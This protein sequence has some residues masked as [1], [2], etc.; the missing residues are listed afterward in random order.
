MINQ[1]NG[2]YNDKSRG[3]LLQSILYISNTCSYIFWGIL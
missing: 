3:V 2:N 1:E